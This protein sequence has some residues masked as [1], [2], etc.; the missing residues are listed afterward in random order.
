MTLLVCSLLGSYCLKFYYLVRKFR[1]VCLGHHIYE[2]RYAWCSGVCV[3]VPMLIIFIPCQ[4]ER[5]AYEMLRSS[6]WTKWPLQS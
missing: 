2:C 3:V 4:F 1:L 5:E 6:C